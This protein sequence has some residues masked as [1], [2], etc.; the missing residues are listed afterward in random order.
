MCKKCF[1]Y[2]TRDMC[3]FCSSVKHNWRNCFIC[4]LQVTDS[5]RILSWNQSCRDVSPIV[6]KS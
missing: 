2:H 5:F 3:K 1:E 4:I 6:M